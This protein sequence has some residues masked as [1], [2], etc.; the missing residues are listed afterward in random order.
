MTVKKFRNLVQ[1]IFL[2]TVNPRSIPLVYFNEIMN[3]GDLISPYLVR[4]IAMR[5]THRARTSVLPRLLGVGSILGSA[6]SNAYVWGSGLMSPSHNDFSISPEKVFAVRG[7]QTRD[8]LFKEH[9]LNKDLVL[10]DPAL[11]MPRFYNPS[12]NVVNGKVGIIPHYV[13]HPTVQRLL[14]EAD[15]SVRLIDVRQ[16]PE[17]FV[18]ELLSCTHIVS[19]S[20]HGLIL[21]DAYRIPNAWVGFNGDIGGGTWKFY[22]YYSTTNTPNRRILKIKVAADIER[23]VDTADSHFQVSCFSENLDDLI[24]S[25]PRR[26]RDAGA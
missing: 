11:L 8:F 4:K 18:D 15:A 9:A 24:R 25:F 2:A 3:V 6:T 12:V 16:E 5:S 26:F 22:D 23:L 7:R 21:A 14:S 19:S 1:D 10:G 13:D 17:A 20:L